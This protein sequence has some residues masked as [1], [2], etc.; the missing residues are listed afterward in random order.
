LTG[1]IR[2]PRCGDAMVANRTKSKTKSGVYVNRMYYSCG[3]FRSKGSS[4][5]STNSIRKLEAEEE[6]IN[7]LKQVLSNDG[8]LQVLVD[9][10]ND[11]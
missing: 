9:K 10:M 4:V 6:V 5:C 1:L 7:R 3:N 11:K 2:C 8:C